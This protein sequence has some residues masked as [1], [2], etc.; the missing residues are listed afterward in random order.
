MSQPQKGPCCV[1]DLNVS[2]AMHSECGPQPEG[3]VRRRVPTV[4]YEDDE[5]NHAFFLASAGLLHV[6]LPSTAWI[7]A[8]S[9]D[10]V[11]QLVQFMAKIGLY[12]E[13]DITECLEMIG[14]PPIS[15][16]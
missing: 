4:R 16:R 8:I 7:R 11:T 15:T 3:W 1:T 2:A 6:L 9:S 5:K 14:R 10:C 13:V 12:W